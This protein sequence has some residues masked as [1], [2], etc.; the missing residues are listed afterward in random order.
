MA[1]RANARWLRA[2]EAAGIVEATGGDPRMRAIS[3]IG[4]AMVVAAAPAWA[5]DKKRPDASE[6]NWASRPTEAEVAAA[7]NPVIKTD[8]LYRAVVRCGVA[9][10][11]ALTDCRIER[12]TPAN[13]G[14]GAATLSLAPKYRRKPPG[15]SDPREV[16]II[17]GDESV[18]K[19]ADWLRR[20]TPEQLLA[21][22]P[23][24]AYRRG[25]SGKAIINCIVT[26]QGALTDCATME[27][28]PAG[29]GFGGAAI[30]LTPQFLMRPAQK[31]GKPVAS[32]VN[33]PINFRMD[34]P[35]DS[36]ATRRVIDAAIAWTEAPTYD[37][38]AEAYPAKARAQRKGGRA[39]VA[40]DMTG[41]GRLADC[42]TIS[43][44]PKGYGFE[45]AAKLLAKRF[46]LEVRSDEDRKAAKGLE[47]H[48]PIVF[49]PGM[50]D[51]ATRVVGKPSWSSL[52]T[53]LQLLAAFK[54]VKAAGSSRAVLDCAVRAGG[55][56]GDCKVTS[57]TPAGVGVAAA[58]LGATPSFRLTT[59]T[60]EG[61]PVVG[62]RVTIPI[63]Y[64]AP[65][66]PAP[67]PK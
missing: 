35:G 50:L 31:G 60:A 36:F 61:L 1:A 30:A 9:D 34:G 16:R 39:T 7:L 40:C 64:E 2:G 10:D 15:K 33:M 47:F 20:P 43:A 48:V 51:P 53:Q 13:S 6:A 29:A 59:W 18:D 21:V 38:V 45:A 58:A 55:V 17:Q 14:V 8:A 32:V 62:G 46:R 11:G 57:E 28:T 25:Q 54:D 26:V 3:W 56:L 5:A 49:D 23:T 27:E 63:R 41:E 22:F 52:P 4:L 65:A 12:E 42:Q 19:A 67:S 44:D 37:E 66:P 24:Q